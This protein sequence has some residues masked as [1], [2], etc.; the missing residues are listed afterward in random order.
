MYY[1][2]Y[3]HDCKVVCMTHAML[4]MHTICADLSLTSVTV[5]LL[6]CG[7]FCLDSESQAIQ[8]AMSIKLTLTALVRVIVGHS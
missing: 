1:T 3:D 8:A 4:G 6:T 2:P 5:H 7:H